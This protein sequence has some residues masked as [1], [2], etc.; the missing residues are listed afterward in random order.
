MFVFIVK[1][2][3]YVSGRIKGTFPM[4]FK[5]REQYIKAI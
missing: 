4:G 1:S 3:K 5:M 2:T